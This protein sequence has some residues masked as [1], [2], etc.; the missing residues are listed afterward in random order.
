MKCFYHDD[1]DG[2]CSAFLVHNFLGNISPVYEDYVLFKHNKHSKE[3]FIK[4]NYDGNFPLDTIKE[5]ELVFIVDYSISRGEMMDLLKKTKNVYWIDHHISAIEKFKNFPHAIK[6]LRV[7]G[8]AACV[9]TYMFFNMPFVN[10]PYMDDES[11]KEIS[12]EEYVPQFIRLIGDRDAWEWRFGDQTK[13]FNLGIQMYETDPFSEI[14]IDLFKSES[15]LLSPPYSKMIDGVCNTGV[16][17][18]RYLDRNNEEYINSYGYESEFEG[19]KVFVCNRAL[20]GSELFGDLF[21]QYDF[22]VTFVFNG[23]QYKY[24]LYSNSIDVSEIAKKYGGGGH[25]GASGFSSEKLL[26]KSLNV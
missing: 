17:I 3:D 19:H 14:W 15:S 26:F 24:S 18:S 6:G 11:I 9:L 1:L 4:M 5:D 2:R 20:C 25:M 22:V 21:Y 23:H 13:F 8:I 12:V 10:C 16:T 7:N